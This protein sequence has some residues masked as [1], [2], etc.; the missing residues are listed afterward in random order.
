MTADSVAGVASC[1][2]VTRHE[3]VDLLAASTLLFDEPVAV[4]ADHI[5]LLGLTNGAEAFGG[6][7]CLYGLAP[8]HGIDLRHWNRM[9]G[10]RQT[11]RGRLDG[12]WC[13]GGTAWG[14]QYAYR[15]SEPGVFRLDA[16]RMEPEPVAASFGEFLR[17]E[18]LRQAERPHD[19]LT[20]Q[21]RGRVG[22][23]EPRQMLL[24]LPSPLGGGGIDTGELAVLP[25]EAVM[26]ENGF[27]LSAFEARFP[28]RTTATLFAL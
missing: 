4:P 19:D 8:R 13:F 12:F 7:I 6:Y 9:D 26:T 1:G 3:P 23:L 11:W 21:A 10:W 28:S 2:L 22:V 5:R 24:P 16:Y 27:R 20:V 25:A 14:D 18:F 15:Q 17:C